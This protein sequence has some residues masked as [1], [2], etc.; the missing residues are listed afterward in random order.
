[1]ENNEER[2]LSFIERHQKDG[3]VIVVSA[4]HELDARITGMYNLLDEIREGLKGYA[5]Y[6][7]KMDERLEKLEPKIQIFG[8]NEGT[9][10]LG[11][12]KD[13]KLTK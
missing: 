3:K 1:M 4:L 8:P 5:E 13:S 12:K 6:M 7:E 10:Y 2:K 9:N 11:L